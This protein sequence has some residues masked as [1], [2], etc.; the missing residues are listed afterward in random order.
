MIKR[1]KATAV[2]LSAALAFSLLSGCGGEAAAPATENVEMDDPNEGLGDL[3][4]D[5][6]EEEE[7]AVNELA[8]SGPSYTGL[9][10]LT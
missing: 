1:T 8:L 6:A 9:E 3:I 4:E 7:A 2:V 10:N 5:E